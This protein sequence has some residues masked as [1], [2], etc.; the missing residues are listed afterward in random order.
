[1][2][3]VPG[4]KPQTIT[5]YVNPNSW[6]YTA[7][8]DRSKELLEYLLRHEIQTR[9]F[10]VPMNQLP[11]FASDIYYHEQDVSGNVYDKCLS[12]PCSTN[13]NDDEVAEVIHKIKQFYA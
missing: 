3:N 8:F 1:M 13:I 9:P 4:F 6:L 11:A 2:K 7:V 12:L 5:E 10:W